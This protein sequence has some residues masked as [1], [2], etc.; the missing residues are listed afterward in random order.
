MSVF[1]DVYL[2]WRGAA[3]AVV[4]LGHGHTDRVPTLL[5]L[6][7]KALTARYNAVKRAVLSSRYAYTIKL[8][9]T[10]GILN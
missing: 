7:K 3:I 10:G 1:F 2:R 9:R 6:N 8:R 4:T 5:D